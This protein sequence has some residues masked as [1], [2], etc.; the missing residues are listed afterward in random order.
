MAQENEINQEANAAANQAAANA[1]QTAQ[2]AT[3]AAKKTV[4]KTA[5]K[6][7]KSTKK[8]AKKATAQAKATVNKTAQANAKATKKATQANNPV[9]AMQEYLNTFAKNSPFNM[10]SMMPNANFQ[11]FNTDFSK[12]MPQMDN[13]QEQMQD[14]A[15][16]ASDFMN[17]AQ[18]AAEKSRNRL[19][20]GMEACGKTF[21]SMAQTNM[22][23]S[24]EAMRT[25]MACKSLNEFAD[26]QNKLFK[27]NFEAMSSESAK[28]LEQVT[29]TVASA[30]EPMNDL[31]ADAMKSAKKNMAA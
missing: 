7:R 5:K 8:T 31:A 14:A 11:N 22:Q 27:Q 17:K 23:R 3:K 10:E 25:L 6:A 21:A 28:L 26:V 4:K 12:S 24:S 15:K 30:S 18:N 20:T 19:T 1:N 29:K 16:D 2:K 9:E 13:V